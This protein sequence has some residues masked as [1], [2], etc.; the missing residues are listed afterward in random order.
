LKETGLAVIEV[1]YV[2]D[3]VDRCEFDTIYHQH[4]CYFSVTALDK[5]FRR[6]ALFLNQVRRIP[7]HGGSLRLFVEPH[8]AVGESVQSLLKEEVARGVHQIDYY[9]DFADRVR[10]IKRS[11][12]DILWD[13]KRNG[14]KIAAYGAAAK[15]TTLLSYGEIDKRL[16]DYVVD[17]NKF[18]HG[19]Y[20]GG[21]HLPIFPPEKLVEDMPDYVLLLA[22]NFADEILRQQGLYRERGGRFI[23]P[24][25]QVRIV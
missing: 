5:L 3:L 13:L 2:V 20:M 9:R 19:R 25:P 7:I 24:I 23:I 8:P 21:N 18:K 22:W 14:K 4:L 17:L 6:H 15:A 11:L 10:E 1:P 16:V 12:L